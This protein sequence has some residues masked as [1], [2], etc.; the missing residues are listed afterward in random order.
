[1]EWFIDYSRRGETPLIIIALVFTA[2]AILFRRK[3]VVCAILVALAFL[4]PAAIAISSNIPARA[5]AQRN[6]CILNL[7]AMQDAKT[8]WAN[9]NSKMTRDI[10][11][12]TNLYGTNGTDGVL[13]YRFKCPSGG[14]YTIGAVG[15]KPTC[16]LSNKGHRLE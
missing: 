4:I 10:A 6:A 15:Q 14:T 3:R 1:M 2:G 5:T 11:A 12:Q 7:R 8:E 9:E 16:S 13:R